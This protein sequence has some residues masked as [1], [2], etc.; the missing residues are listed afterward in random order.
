V[1]D[2]S[3]HQP[4]LTRRLIAGI[5]YPATYRGFVEMFPGEEACLRY[6]EALRWPDGFVCLACGSSGEPWRV[7]R[8]RLVCRA[9]RHQACHRG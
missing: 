2:A 4:H 5:D 8:G 1:V 7:S 6:V 3:A 9:C